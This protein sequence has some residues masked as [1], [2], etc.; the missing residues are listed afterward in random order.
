M[1]EVSRDGP[2]DGAPVVVS[3]ALKE[4]YELAARVADV[5]A[6]VFIRGEPGVGKE[7]LAR[8]FHAQSPR[9]SK[10][11]GS[12]NCEA[13]GGLLTDELLGRGP[14]ATYGPK[15]GL[16]EK[17]SGG[18][19]YLAAVDAM[20][21]TVQTSLMRV[22]ECQEVQRLKEVTTR[23]VDLRFIAGT[24]GNIAAKVARMTFRT[25][26]FHHLC[27][28]T[29]I[30]PPLRD[31]PEDIEPLAERFLSEARPATGRHLSRS[32]LDLLRSFAWTGNAR[33]LRA[34]LVRASRLS[35]GHEITPKHLDI[36]AL[37]KD[38]PAQPSEERSGEP[39]SELVLTPEERAERRRMVVAL[40]NGNI[41][42][43]AVCLG[44]TRRTFVSKMER[45]QIPRPE[46]V[47]L[48][49]K[50]PKSGAT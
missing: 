9:A 26:L 18:T 37:R 41:T 13:P 19:V 4:I 16:L 28:T 21:L 35:D 11:F 44:V 50:G 14:L 22:I 7:T 33:Q 3:A 48:T 8:W 25:D 24:S 23:S 47:E 34:V 42:R 46:P 32:A 12:I 40:S 39:P 49:L 27:A 43:S 10:P 20:D 36:E 31:R 30:I 38:H 5:P 17:A 29:F 45:Y 1:D 6:N 2:L 15:V